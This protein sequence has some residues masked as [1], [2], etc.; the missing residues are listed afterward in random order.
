MRKYLV[1]GAGGWFVVKARNKAKARSIGVMEFG[2]GNVKSVR[3]A[4]DEEADSY[5]LQ[6]GRDTLIEE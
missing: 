6:T 4:T 3:L 2:L 5:L 1:D